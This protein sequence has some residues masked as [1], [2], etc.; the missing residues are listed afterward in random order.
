VKKETKK[1]MKHSKLIFSTL[2]AV[3]IKRLNK[4]DT[5]APC[6][7]LHRLVEEANIP[8][9]FPYKPLPNVEDFRVKF[10]SPLDPILEASGIKKRIASAELESTPYRNRAMN[11]YVKYQFIRLNKSRANPDRFWKIATHLLFRSHSYRTMCVNHVYPQWQRRYKYNVIKHIL[12]SLWTLNLH[13]YT[14]KTKFIPKANGEYRPLGVPAPAW[15]ILLHGLNNIM[16]V[17]LTPYIH[18]EQ[19]G[20][21]PKRGTLT[22]WKSIMRKLDARSIYEFDLRKYF[23]S[24]NLHYLMNILRITGIP[25]HIITYILRWNQ[26]LPADKTRHGITW[27]T[28][29]EEASDYKYS[30][31]GKTLNGYSDYTYWINKKKEEEQTNPLI[32]NYEYYRGVSQGMPTSPLLA[33]IILAPQLIKSCQDIVL[34]ADDGLI[35]SSEN[36]IVPPVFTPESGIKLNLEKSY[37]I[38]RQG[39]WIK[40][41]KFL[42]VTYEAGSYLSDST[43]S[44]G[45]VRNSTRTP[46][47]FILNQLD[48][49]RNAGYYKTY[50]GKETETYD[51]W[52]KTK[53]S[54]YLMSRL[55]NGTYKED[56]VLQDFLLNYKP[57]S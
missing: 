9:A 21:T 10:V 53:L 1:N 40:P 27:S 57:E 54:G 8:M 16:L 33:S 28:P 11:R 2:W 44:G 46:K 18:P 32:R 29:L 22:A 51:H 52:F 41:L 39:K 26:T 15:R 42:G 43:V 7:E 20:F 25:N 17:W 24:V 49:F 12:S 50:E 37:M 13:K 30:K 5:F 35:F 56:D 6:P 47:P 14:Y 38:K 3:V 55:Y 36:N 45:Q 4:M 19:H 48:L 31:I 34:Y 23:D